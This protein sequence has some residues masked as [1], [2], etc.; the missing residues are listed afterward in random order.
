MTQWCIVLPL[1]KIHSLK[2]IV[3]KPMPSRFVPVVYCFPA[4][5]GKNLI[6]RQL[7]SSQAIFAVTAKTASRQ[8]NSFS[9]EE[10]KEMDFKEVIRIHLG[11][12]PFHFS[13]TVNGNI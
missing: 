13:D 12:E 3:E 10:R 11:Q 6:R 4:N 2:R 7:T 9:C 1:V 5:T 8:D